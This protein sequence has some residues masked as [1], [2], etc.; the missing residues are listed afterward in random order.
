MRRVKDFLICLL[1]VA[2]ATVS[3]AAP[4]N[5][6]FKFTPTIDVYKVEV[7]D[8]IEVNPIFPARLKSVDSCVVR[9]KVDGTIV[10]RLF[11]E[12]SFVKKGEVLFVI[13]PALYKA[14]VDSLF[15]QLKLAKAKL[16]NAKSNYLRI[17]K[18]FKENLVSAQKRDDAFF[19]YQQ[20]KANVEVVKAQLEDA[21]IR[22]SY[23]KVKAP[24]SGY[25]REKLIDVGNYVKVGDALVEIDKIKPI[26]AEFSIPD[27]QFLKYRDDIK[28]GIRVYLL[29][30]G[31]IVGKLCFVD[32]VIDPDTST[33]KA[34]A[35]FDN[36]DLKL[37]PNQFV[38]VMLGDVYYREVAKIPQSVVIQTE[39]FPMVYLIKDNVVI[40][41]PIKI[42]AQKDGFFIVKGLKSSDL[43]AYDNLMKIRPKMKIKIGKIVNR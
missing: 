33:V 26:Y 24:I 17:E 23:T 28:N 9:A 2:I 38:R 29:P 18:S 5:R 25:V 32:K 30:K 1:I 15:A 7:K 14:K 27:E 16:E 12:G 36:N 10:K 37:M 42:V 8:K 13:D 35:I 21:K 3:F 20:A 31:K 39:H 19:G 11:R 6:H 34:K 22:L 40:P 4:K 43:V 41:K